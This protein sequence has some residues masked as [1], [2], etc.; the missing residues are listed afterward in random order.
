M[1]KQNALAILHEITDACGKSLIVQCVSLDD[2]SSQIA[3]NGNGY[4]I[5]MKCDLDKNSWRCIKPILKKHNLTIK[6]ADGYL[7]IQEP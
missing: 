3:K 6:V 4:K 2:L 5:K 1:N 7:I